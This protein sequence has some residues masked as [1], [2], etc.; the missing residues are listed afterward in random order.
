[1][2]VASSIDRVLLL[3]QVDA[4][5][6]QAV[7]CT[8]REVTRF[9]LISKYQKHDGRAWQAVPASTIVQKDEL[10]SEADWPYRG[11]HT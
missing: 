3:L 11:Y 1:M 5:C 8:G 4:Q 2:P 9:M 7:W 10:T 6:F